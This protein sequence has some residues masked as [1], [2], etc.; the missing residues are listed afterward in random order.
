VSRGPASTVVCLLG[1]R[2]VVLA[3]LSGLG[4]A[5]NVRVVAPEE[6]P[7]LDRALAAWAEASRA[8]VPYVV[9]DADP[10]AEVAETWRAR[11]D[12]ALA[13][14]VPGALEAAVGGFLARAR[15]GSLGLPDHYLALDPEGRDPTVRH[16]VLGWLAAAAPVRVTPGAGMA[17]AVTRAL[18]ALAP[19][20]GGPSQPASSTAWTGSCPSGPARRPG[21]SGA[22]RAA[23]LHVTSGISSRTLGELVRFVIL[24]LA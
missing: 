13:G 8:L 24:P 3:V 21:G 17:S 6:G 5:G 10:L 2:E 22:R 7:A 14:G 4:S 15:A 23:A 1:D 11:F 12:P 18:P 20:A 16:F 19:A 9:H